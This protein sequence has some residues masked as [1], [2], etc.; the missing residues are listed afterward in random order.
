MKS[1]GS[2]YVFTL[3]TQLAI[4]NTVD[5]LSFLA[6][7][8]GCFSSLTPRWALSV[9]PP[10]SD[11]NVGDHILSSPTLLSRAPCKAISLDLSSSM[12]HGHLKLHMHAP[13]IYWLITNLHLLPYVLLELQ[14]LETSERQ[15]PDS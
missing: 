2:L 11:G 10:V 3:L 14:G 6:P 13:D 15:R 9:S 8:V 7:T 1:S 4:F 12:F 5:P